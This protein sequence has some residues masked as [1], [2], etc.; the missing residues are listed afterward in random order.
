MEGKSLA[1]PVVVSDDEDELYLLDQE[2]TGLDDNEIWETLECY[3]NLPEIPHP[4][5]N[6]L[7]YA[8]IREQQQHD[9][10][11]LALQ[12][13]Y[14]D[15]YVNLQLDDDV[16]DII[17]YK[18]DPIQDNWKIA[19]PETMVLDTVKWFHQIMGRPGDKRLSESLKQRYLDPSLRGHIEQLKCTDCQK[20]KIPGHGYKLLPERE[21]CVAP[22]EEVA[23]DLIGPWEVKVSGRKVES[24]ALTCI[25]TASNLVELI[26]I[27]NKTSKHIRDK[28]TQCR[29]CRYPRPM[30][31]VRDKGGKFVGSSF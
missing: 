5:C 17:C 9:G 6:P 20:Y 18:K 28:F 3:L 16:D 14:V 22:W 29:C 2:Y 12:A 10:N 7:N 26:R 4:E 23:I 21:V 8:H 25:D 27:D 19:L 30:C 15:Y 13:K 24:N 31:C 1:D 11:L